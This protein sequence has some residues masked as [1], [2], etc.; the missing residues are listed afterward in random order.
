MALVSS[1]LAIG[2]GLVALIGGIQNPA[3]NQPLFQITK[4]GSIFDPGNATSWCEV[5]SMQGQGGPGASGGT[6]IGWLIK[7]DVTFQVTAGVGPYET[8]SSDAETNMLTIQ[9]LLLPTLRQYPK[10][11]LATNPMQAIQSVY[12][13]LV[14]AADRS[15]PAKLPN[16]HVYKLWHVQVVISQQYN[17]ELIQL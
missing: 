8:N 1:R 16:G 14:S 11:P 10:L 17:L 15:Q 4:L 3:T 13:M 7:E 9:D 5:V 2:Q 6:Q 12:E